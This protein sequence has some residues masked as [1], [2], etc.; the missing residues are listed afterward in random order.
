[1]NNFAQ[2]TTFFVKSKISGSLFEENYLT[3]ARL[4]YR[5]RIYINNS[6]IAFIT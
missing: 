2:D 3:L 5:L 1:V 6:E 4:F